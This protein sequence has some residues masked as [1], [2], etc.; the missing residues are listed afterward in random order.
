MIFPVSKIVALLSSAMRLYPGDLIFTGTPN[1]V[2]PLR[3]GDVCE[4]EIQ[5]IGVLRNT[6][7]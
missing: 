2:G 1:G 6:I 4:I 7:R 5:G 3:P